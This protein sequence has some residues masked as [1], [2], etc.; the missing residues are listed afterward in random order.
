MQRLLPALCAVALVAGC[1]TTPVSHE[2]LAAPAQEELL[3]ALPGFR[4][5]GRAAVPRLGSA[6]LSWRQR[7]ADSRLRLGNPL[8]PGSMTL[9]YTP[10]T[11]RVTSSRGDE[12][13]GAAAEQF[14]SDQLGFVPPFEALRYWVL[15]LAAPGEPPVGQVTDTTGRITE[16]TQLDWRIR[17]D[18]WTGMAT[19]AGEVRLPLR[20]TATRAD[21][22]LTVV[23]DR[24]KLQAAD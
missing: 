18:R 16:M 20:M 19:P 22:R 13:E 11:L 8:G 15:G 12:F 1:A 17:Y 3:R 21:L 23:V 4:F 10:A 7:A 9:A 24:W 14:L 6:T 2:T 5:D